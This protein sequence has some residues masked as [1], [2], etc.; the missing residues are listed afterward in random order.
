MMWGAIR[1]K[2]ENDSGA[3]CSKRGYLDMYLRP[4]HRS[5][6]SGSWITSIPLNLARSLRK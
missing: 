1:S 6:I 4:P 3:C 5:R 2:M